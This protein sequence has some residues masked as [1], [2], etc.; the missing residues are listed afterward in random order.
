MNYEEWFC[1][2]LTNLRLQKGTSARDMSL[3]LGQSESYINKIENKKALPSMMGLFYIC[4]YFGITPRDFF[5]EESAMP[6]RT[7]EFITY[8][9]KLTSKQAEYVLAL[10]KDITK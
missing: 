4:D 6:Q 1:A 8:I 9:E 10:L 3:S 7:Q 2:R 5:D